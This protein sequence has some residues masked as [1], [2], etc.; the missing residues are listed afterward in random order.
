VVRAL[1]AL[2]PLGSFHSLGPFCPLDALGA[3]GSFHALRTLGPFH[4]LRALDALVPFD[5]RDPLRT[6][7]AAI[8]AP[9][10]TSVFAPVSVFT[11]VFAT[12]FTPVGAALVRGA[13]LDPQAIVVL[14]QPH[15][16]EL[17]VAGE[18]LHQLRDLGALLRRQ[19]TLADAHIAHA[20]VE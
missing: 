18:L 4:T 17:E 12:V 9:V 20:A 5:P 19:V 14:A 6:V 10:F 1:D 11:P 15:A 16:L 8:D 7:F 2:W 3:L 13:Q